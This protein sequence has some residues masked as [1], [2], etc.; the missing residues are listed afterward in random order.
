MDER[1]ETYCR[2]LYEL[3]YLLFIYYYIRAAI[4]S[5][6]VEKYFVPKQRRSQK[7]SLE[8]QKFIIVILWNKAVLI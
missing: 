7:A 5:L 1:S 8:G 6:A 4:L 3:F 2:S